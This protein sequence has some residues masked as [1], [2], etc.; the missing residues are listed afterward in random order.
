MSTS[1]ETPRPLAPPAAPDTGEAS[2]QADFALV[3]GGGGARGLAHIGALE[4]LER[5]RLRPSFLVGTSMGG[6]LAVL[7]AADVPAAE[8]RRLAGEFRF[9][10]WFVPGAFVGWDRIFRPVARLL[11][12]RRFEDLARPAAVV[13]VDLEAG[14]PVVLHRGPLL[15]ALRATCAV[16]G[17]LP[18]VN[19]QGRWMVD[20]ALVNALPVDVASMA[21]PDVVLAVRTGGQGY[22]PLPSLRHPAAAALERLGAVLPNPLSAR[23]GFEVLV[24]STEI[25][26]DRQ[27]TLSAAMV[28]PTVLVDVAVGDVGMRDFHRL[29]EAAAAGRAG[30]ERALPALCAALA[31]A[32]GRRGGGAALALHVD[33][34]CDMVVSPRRAAAAETDGHE[35][36]YFCSSTCRDAFLRRAAQAA[37]RPPAGDS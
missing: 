22:R 10:R 34:I 37:S 7:A 30:M 29:G 31:C 27:T 13:A 19:V 20:G 21:D 15:P 16:P 1:A 26:L 9:P 3:L 36:R 24:R 35:V 12:G 5:Q 2:G 23:A 14:R 11:A 6:V 25:A 8:I 33:P 4:V 32:A 28:E 18:P 17:V